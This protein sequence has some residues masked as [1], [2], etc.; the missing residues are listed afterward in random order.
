[1]T[2]DSPER[3][4]ARSVGADNE[5]PS[6]GGAVA[7]LVH[8]GV[9]LAYEQAGSGDPPMVFV[10]GW[11]CDHTYFAPQFEHFASSHRVVAVD[12]RGHGAS[13][14]PESGYGIDVLAEDVAYLCDELGVS[15]AVVVGH[16]MGALVA[17]ELGA[18]HG[19]LSVALVLVDPALIAPGPEM[20]ASLSA[21][22]AV[23][24]GPDPVEARRGFAASRLFL[25]T[26]DTGLKARILEE[27]AS[28]PNHV[29]RGCFEAMVTWPGGEA[30][31]RVDV[32]VLAI[33]A[34]SPINAPEHLA[35]LCPTLANARTPGVGHFNQ[36]LAPAEVNRL[37]EDFAARVVG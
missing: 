17:V 1:M 9:T 24:A 35:A 19:S 26:D 27:M 32:P 13:D 10:H 20:V 37:I 6:E 11:T 31:R 14:A 22:V 34:H 7:T 30:I 36:L 23:M 16:S 33:H 3:P 21:F 12:L 15:G 25:P 4:T 2:G 18:N 5:G 8:D 29:A 28:V